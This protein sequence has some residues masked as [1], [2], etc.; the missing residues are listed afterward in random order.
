[1][2]NSPFPASAAL[3]SAEEAGDPPKTPSEEGMPFQERLRSLTSVEELALRWLVFVVTLVV[4]SLA[5]AFSL[6]DL[7]A[8]SVLGG[9]LAIGGTLF[10]AFAS[11]VRPNSAAAP[12]VRRINIIFSARTIF[13]LAILLLA[14]H[15]TGGMSSPL[16]LFFP[17]AVYVIALRSRRSTGRWV[18]ISSVTAVALLAFLEN[19]IWQPPFRFAPTSTM[20][21]DNQRFDVIV[22]VCLALSAG[23]V[24]YRA[25]GLTSSQWSGQKTL[26][27]GQVDT[28]GDA[29]QVMILRQVGQQLASSLDL[30]TL[31]DTI[32]VSALRFSNAND[33]HLFLY[34]EKT[35]EFGMGVGAW[36]DGQRRLAVQK[37]RKV[38]LCSSV[39]NAGEPVLIED[40]ENH[41]LFATPEALHW[42]MKS[43]GGFPIKKSDHVVGVLNAAFVTPHHFSDEE[44]RMLLALADQAALAI[45]NAS[46]YRQVEQRVAELSALSKINH[47][48][49]QSLQPQALMSEALKAVQ[50]IMDAPIALFD[51]FDESRGDLELAAESG[52]APT[53]VEELRG[54]HL[55]I[56]EGFAG[57]VVA[58]GGS[59]VV[60]DAQNDPLN[61][62]T[63]IREAR[64]RALAAVPLKSKDRVIGVVEVM[65]T[66]ATEFT[67]GDVHLLNAIAQ[68]IAVAL[69]NARLYD[70]ARRQAEQLNA[71]RE[72]GLA[73]TSSLELREQLRALHRHVQALLHPDSFFVALCDEARQEL[74]VQFVVEDG[75][76]LRGPT[77]PL[78]SAGLS[79]WVIRGGQ[80]LCVGDAVHDKEKLPATPRHETRPARSWL[81]VPLTI[82]DR[83]IGIVSVQSFRPD[84]F[85]IADE[86]FLVSVAQHT[87]LAIENARLYETTAR[88]TRES[89]ILNQVTGVISA[90][91]DLET[92]LDTSAR[93]LGDKFG[94]QYVTLYMIESGEFRLHAQIG[95]DAA[96][97]S[98]PLSVGV[99]GRVARTGQPSLVKDVTADPDFSPCVPGVNSEIAIP[100]RADGRVVGVVDVQERRIDAL[101]ES[102]LRIMST[103]G[104]HLS[105]AVTNALLYQSMVHRERLATSLRRVAAA[106]AGSADANQI[107]DTICR[108]TQMFFRTESAFL[109]LVEGDKLVAVAARGHH[110]AEFLRLSI[111]LDDP[112]A[113]APQV[114][115]LKKPVFLNQAVNSPHHHSLQTSRFEPQALVAAPLMLDGNAF[116]ALE[117][118]DEHNANRFGPADLEWIEQ[119]AALAS[120]ALANL[121]WRQL[122]NNRQPS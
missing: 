118:A 70:E 49:S 17:A 57:R 21:L 85:S 16:L 15:F 107:M 121:G 26:P 106:L 91:L 101:H 28:N 48:V 13:D 109:W 54:H 45:S 62:R 64:V 67:P 33:V 7:S 92:I 77:V 99:A 89:E 8:L 39:V 23:Y 73:L 87:A 59:L 29:S 113:L 111:N 30:D 5:F 35:N 102:D 68:P 37:P 3:Y 10:G 81:G 119:F 47:R 114:V 103:F 88:R 6:P 63:A 65:R 18:A 94:Y 2:S 96:L 41:P 97:I 72:I 61:A 115:R 110:R 82:Q 20:S 120:T 56:G 80:P 98:Q 104:E 112:L 14:L 42:N 58:T 36:A 60:N 24:F 86:R 69:D 34:D 122:L 22:V 44:C 55:K 100:I 117:L 43:I 51:L 12:R 74:S 19:S 93:V 71:L 50:E 78:D 105:S 46:L 25:Y 95:Y 1:M 83:V 66:N 11:Q 32:A 9:L 84:M 90:S 4:R 52:F 75:W 79:S 116:G 108:E 31:L 38:G 53:A 27:N 40:V 76:E